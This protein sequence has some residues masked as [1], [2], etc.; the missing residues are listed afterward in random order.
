V[1]KTP[2]NQLVEDVLLTVYDR[3]SRYHSDTWNLASAFKAMKRDADPEIVEAVRGTIIKR[4]WGTVEAFGDKLAFTINERGKADAIDIYESRK[5]KTAIEKL[6][7]Y[8]WATWGGLAA[9]V[10]AA[11]SIAA[12]L[13]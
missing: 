4:G 7:S 11:A 6:H 1:T 8:N 13:K 5:P 3:S 9:V 10:A 12:L 2:Y